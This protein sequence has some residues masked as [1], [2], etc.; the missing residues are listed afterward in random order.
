[1]TVGHS[2]S[3]WGSHQPPKCALPS[4]RHVDDAR[5]KKQKAL[6]GKIPRLMEFEGHMPGAVALL[7]EMEKTVSLIAEVFEGTQPLSVYAPPV[8]HDEPPSRLFV[9]DALTNPDHIK[10]GLRGCLAASLCYII[11][12]AVNH[13]QNQHR[14]DHVPADGAF[15]DWLIP[16][17]TGVAFQRR[18]G[19]HRSPSVH[20]AFSRFHRRLHAPFRSRHD[21]GGLDCNFF[22]PPVVLW[23]PGRRSVRPYQ[24]AGIQNA[25]LPC[26]GKGSRPRHFAR[27][28]DNVAGV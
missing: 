2:T 27:P 10:F 28:P 8:S 13:P 3:R 7:G 19:G 18:P 4:T 17:E 12:T 16:P 6:A 9:A 1:M 21:P 20:S 25:D 24:P 11:Y 26:R 15:H 23:G 14:R 5:K 22:A